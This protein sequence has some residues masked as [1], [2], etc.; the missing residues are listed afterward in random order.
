MLKKG[1]YVS[2]IDLAELGIEPALL[3][4]DAGASYIIRELAYH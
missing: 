4:G 3:M 1:G 2:G